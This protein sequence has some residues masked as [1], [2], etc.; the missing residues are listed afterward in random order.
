MS[1]IPAVSPAISIDVTQD[2]ESASDLR[3]LIS[4]Q[5]KAVLQVASVFA[6]FA[7]QEVSNAIGSA[8]LSLSL[9][10]TPNWKTAS[11]ISFSLK[12][13]AKCAIAIADRGTAFPVALKVDSSE[14]TDIQS[15]VAA[16]VTFI[17]IDLDFDVSGN[18]SGSGTASGVGISGKASGSASTT[19]SFCQP[20]PSNTETIDAVRQA[21]SAI[22]FPTAPDSALRM[23]AGSSCRMN[24]DAKL[25]LAVNASYGLADFK[26][27]APSAALVQQS[28]GKAFQKLT[29]PA[30]EIKAGATASLTYSHTDRFGIVLERRDES[31][32]LL[33]LMRSASDETGESAGISVGITT[34]EA[35]VAFDSAQISKTVAM[36]TGS[37]ALGQKAAD[38]V[39]QPVNN[40]ETAAVA[41]LNTFIA[42]VNGTAGL[43]VALSQQKGRTALFNFKM[44]LSRK[45]ITEQS[46]SALL[47]GDVAQAMSIGGFALLPGSGVAEHLRRAAT[48]QF[49]FFNLFACSDTQSFFDNSYVEA[50]PD[51]TIRFFTDIGKEDDLTV[52]KALDKMR[53]HFTATAGRDA[54]GDI[55]QAA[56]DLHIEISEKGNPA[57]AALLSK[58]ASI[59]AMTAYSKANPGG[60]LTLIAVLKP[61]AC[62]QIFFSPYSNG[63]PPKNPALDGINWNAIHHAAAETMNLPFVKPWTFAQWGRYNSYCNTGGPDAIPDRRGFGPASN[64]PSEFW[65]NF[66]GQARQVAYFLDSSARGMNLFEDL[67][68]L[69]NDAAGVTTVAQWNRVLDRLAEIVTGDVSIDYAKA[70]S[71]AILSLAALAGAQT[72]VDTA[73]AK[74]ASSFTATLT[75]A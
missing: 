68:T 55:T 22:V 34:T 65:G 43:S 23:A 10:A 66:Q 49:H 59:D 75:L 14:T 39:S 41:R 13:E 35:S 5:G 38:A 45:D 52:R 47:S 6:R 57:G 15:P 69:S 67:A 17:N 19:L 29:L 60:N 74:D 7:G 64:V 53:F 58:V 70:I 9:G 63:K 72:T 50:G 4:A 56:I 24:F 3:N 11:G 25:N 8:P 32:A 1:G 26:V 28:V 37:A 54:Q 44:D 16:G 48:L 71:A 31:T 40:V 73:Q 18:V 33:Y 27:S 2:L 61:S 46:W 51:G 42:N 12:P 62:G 30:T 21:L 20:V 36:V